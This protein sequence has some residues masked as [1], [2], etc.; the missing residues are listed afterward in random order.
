MFTA[1]SFHVTYFNIMIIEVFLKLIKMFLEFWKAIRIKLK[2]VF[3]RNFLHSD[4]M[5]SV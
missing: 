2:I 3:F 5:I 4:V 1:R